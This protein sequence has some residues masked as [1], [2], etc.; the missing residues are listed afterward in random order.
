MGWHL[1]RY[2]VGWQ[3]DGRAS[4]GHHAAGRRGPIT[5]TTSTAFTTHPPLH[6]RRVA[7]HLPRE[8]F[9]HLTTPSEAQ[10]ILS[11]IDWDFANACMVGHAAKRLED[12][13]RERK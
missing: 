6:Q 5:G 9:G 8:R 3:H 12:I 11:L 4:P 10:Q 2:S 13:R 7:I 1:R